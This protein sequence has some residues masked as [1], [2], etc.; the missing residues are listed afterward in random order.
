MELHVALS[1]R[2]DAVEAHRLAN[3]YRA[4]VLA[5]NGDAAAERDCLAMAV[6]FALQWNESAPVGLREG[7]EQI[8]AT[9][10]A[11]EEEATA[12]AATATPFFQ[13]GR[14]YTE[15]APF[16]A[17]EDRPNFQCV[18]VAIHPTTGTRRALGFEQPGAGG[19]WKSASFRDEEWADGWTDVTDTTT[20]KDRP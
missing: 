13:P 10:P 1:L 5:E 8:L 12:A 18:A 20:T 6:Q 3:A 4:E 9:M 16:R 15:A 17:P 2:L 7:I 14:T 11:A 19:P